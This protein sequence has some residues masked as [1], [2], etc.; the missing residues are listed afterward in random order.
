MEQEAEQGEKESL[1]SEHAMVIV[2]R[3]TCG[4]R[5]AFEDVRN[6]YTVWAESPSTTAQ[7]GSRG[8]IDEAW[9]L[10]QANE[11][12]AKRLYIVELKADCFGVLKYDRNMS[13][14]WVWVKRQRAGSDVLDPNLLKDIER[15]AEAQGIDFRHP[16][17]RFTLWGIEPGRMVFLCSCHTI[18]GAFQMAAAESLD[19]PVHVVEAEVHANSMLQLLLRVMK[20]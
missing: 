18:E 19:A 7:C 20:Q 1:S 12:S 17:Y 11:R 9:A 13:H 16:L 6:R 5:P 4:G 8:T 15:S 10:A 2:G 3:I 14:D